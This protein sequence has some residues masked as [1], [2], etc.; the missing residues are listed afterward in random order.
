M[1]IGFDFDNTIVSYDSLFHKVAREQAHIP[2]DTPV[3]KNA[4]RDYL[5]AQGHEPVWTEMQGYVYGARM[6][7]AAAYPHAIA[8]IEALGKAGHELAI[9]SHKTRTPYAGPAY[10]LHAAARGW[11]ETHLR[12]AAGDALIPAERIFFLET[13]PEKIARIDALRCDAFI[14]DLP[15]ILLHVGFPEYTLRYLFSASPQPNTQWTQVYD[16]KQFHALMQ[17]TQPAT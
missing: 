15:E 12:N 5:R 11:I 3:N 10:D 17:A 16:W 9:I 6:N 7:E 2:E 13:K 1:R 14:D 8:T 4:V